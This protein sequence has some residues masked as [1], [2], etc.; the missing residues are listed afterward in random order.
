MRKI[1]EFVKDRRIVISIFLF[2]FT[3]LLNLSAPYFPWYPTEIDAHH[4]V[5]SSKNL[6][7]GRWLTEYNAYY[8]KY[9][10][11]RRVLTKPLYHFFVAAAGLVLKTLNIHPYYP[12]QAEIQPYV[13]GGILV[14]MISI[15]LTS[16]ITFYLCN[17]FVKNDLISFFTSVLTV[18]NPA[19]LY[20]SNKVYA[21]SLYL[22]IVLSSLYIFFKKETDRH[23]YL[24][25]VVGAISGMVRPTGLFVPVIL[26][27]AHFWRTRKL[28]TSITGKLKTLVIGAIVSFLTLMPLLIMVETHPEAILQTPYGPVKDFWLAIFL[29]RVPGYLSNFWPIMKAMALFIWR[30]HITQFGWVYIVPILF[31]IIY[32]V[33]KERSV[34]LGVFIYM[35]LLTFLPPFIFRGHIDRWDIISVPFYFLISAIATK[36]I[37]SKIFLST[38]QTKKN[39]NRTIIILAV[40]LVIMNY[41]SFYNLAYTYSYGTYGGNMTRQVLI[42]QTVMYLQDN[43]FTKIP[44]YLEPLNL[45]GGLPPSEVIPEDCIFVSDPIEWVHYTGRYNFFS[46][47]DI[48]IDSIRKA[49]YLIFESWVTCWKGRHPFKYVQKELYSGTGTIRIS[50]DETVYPETYL[51]PIK[52]WENELGEK[53]ILYKVEILD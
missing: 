36:S 52:V 40:L 12:M 46:G 19:L 33:S 43:I 30:W 8:G 17:L 31:S 25:C 18:S 15:S 53:I 49:K 6:A 48:T 44:K 37:S 10:Y 29:R 27:I 21:E 5:D 26:I 1:E 11:H 47:W 28:K 42:S 22:F 39:F 41:V 13:L 50:F 7:E 24:S 3:F 38:S 4:F 35:L 45:D 20:Y 23:F 32:C 34:G 51:H 9:I 2:S 14:S 16:I